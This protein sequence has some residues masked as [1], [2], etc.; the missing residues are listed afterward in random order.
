MKS[1][2][3]PGEVGFHHKVIS[4]TA[5]GFIPF[6]RTDI[7]KNTLCRLTKGVS[8]LGEASL[9]IHETFFTANTFGIIAYLK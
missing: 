9:N 1:T 4:S 7:T 3:S 5:G 6:V 8:S 2:L